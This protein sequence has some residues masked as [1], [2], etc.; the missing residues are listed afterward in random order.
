MGQENDRDCGSKI[1]REGVS[2]ADTLEKIFPGME[3][4]MSRYL[5]VQC[6]SKTMAEPQEGRKKEVTGAGREAK[7]L[8]ETLAC[9]LSQKAWYSC[10]RPVPQ[11]TAS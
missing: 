5:H 2:P 11:A 9:L 3:S 8:V 4:C 10:L 6:A 7:G 1:A